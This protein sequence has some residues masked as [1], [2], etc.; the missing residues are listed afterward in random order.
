MAQHM[1]CPGKCRARTWRIRTM[2]LGRVIFMS[3]LDSV[4]YCAAGVLW[5]LAYLLS[6]CSTHESVGYSSLQ[7][8]L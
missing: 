7:L 2:L 5:F 6:G 8:L 1:V 4:G 3:L